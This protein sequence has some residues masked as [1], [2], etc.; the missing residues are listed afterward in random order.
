MT[1]NVKALDKL[2]LFTSNNKTFE[3]RDIE[4]ALLQAVLVGAN[5]A[6]ASLITAGAR[7]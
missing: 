4:E 5:D 2:L 7:R 3:L 6:I 1:K